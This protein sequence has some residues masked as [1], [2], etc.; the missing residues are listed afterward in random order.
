M[1]TPTGIRKFVINQNDKPFIGI[2]KMTKDC[3]YKYDIDS[4]VLND[5]CIGDWYSFQLPNDTFVICN[6][7]VYDCL[8]KVYQVHELEDKTHFV[9][10]SK[11]QALA[12]EEKLNKTISDGEIAN[13]ILS[14]YD[15]LD[16]HSKEKATNIVFSCSDI[17]KFF[18]TKNVSKINETI[19]LDELAPRISDIS[20]RS[21]LFDIEW[22]G[23]TQVNVM[24]GVSGNICGILISEANENNELE[25]LKD[26]N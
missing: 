11:D 18:N 13:K 25:R 1:E 17:D 10:S 5:I 19:D 26:E 8:E 9:A 22:D 7:Q 23:D 4:L 6:D 24:V 21:Y 2:S 12:L 15:I 16:L 20:E 3:E 14:S